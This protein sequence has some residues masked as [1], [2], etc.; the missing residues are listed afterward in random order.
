V[1][2]KFG[3]L[4]LFSFSFF[5]MIEDSEH[6]SVNNPFAIGLLL[7]GFQVNRLKLTTILTT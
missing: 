2:N 7:E 5:K 3:L 1:L 6:L 4:A